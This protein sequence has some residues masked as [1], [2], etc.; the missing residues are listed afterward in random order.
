M[1]NLVRQTAAHIRVSLLG[2]L[3]VAGIF[4][5]NGVGSQRDSAIKKRQPI[6]IA[7]ISF[8]GKAAGVTDDGEPS[9]AEV[10]TEKLG[11]VRVNLAKF[12]DGNAV[13][14]A[15]LNALER[16]KKGIRC[17]KGDV[18][19]LLVVLEEEGDGFIGAAN[20]KG[21]EDRTFLAVID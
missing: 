3:V 1:R 5:A 15:I 9:W 7:G 11:T 21:L 20:D 16:E 2:A 10:G 4:V 19:Q 12:S 8:E 18:N 6:L 14:L 17:S 13:A